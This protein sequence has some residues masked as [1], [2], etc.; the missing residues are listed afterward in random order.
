M[1]EPVWIL[2]E[3]L[4]T[5]HDESIARDGGIHGVRDSGLLDSALARAQNTFGYENVSDV[6]RLAANYA[7]GLAKNHPFA[8]GNKRAAFLA[9]GTFLRING[10]RLTA[11]QTDATRTMYDLASSKIDEDTFAAW[12]KA[13]SAV[14]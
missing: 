10:L 7:F 4:V 11:S 3:A 12:L 2:R 1:S 6:P 13:N 8:D 5:L 9:A 14:L